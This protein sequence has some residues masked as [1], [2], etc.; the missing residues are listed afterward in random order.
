MTERRLYLD[1]AAGETRGVVT[2]DGRPERLLISRDGDLA[3]QALGARVVARVRAV[4]RANALAFLD[5]G[6]GPDAVLNVTKDQGPLVEGRAL[7]VEIRAEG[8]RDKGAS[9]RLLG[10][11]EG[12]PRLLAAAPTVEEQLLGFAPGAAIRDGTIA[13]SVADGA[14]DEALSTAFPLPGGGSVSVEPTRALIA[15]DV[16]LG[17][18]PGVEAKKATRAANFAALGV[19]A[20]AMRLK[21]LGGLAVIDLVGRGHDAPALLSAARAAFGPDN[22]GVALGAVSRF[23]TLELTVP[24]R[25]RPAV[26]I[27]TDDTGAPSALTRALVLLRALEREAMAD[28]GGRF[29]AV[30][31]AAVARAAASGLAILV[32]RLGARLAVRADP[33]RADS[34]SEVARL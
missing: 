28:G 2:L 12:P 3:V 9:V 13:R 31:S 10:P 32:A 1:V 14:Q 18:R 16:D 15:I 34:Q 21:G 4:D 27:L 5:L 19:A 22:P 8:R 29:E 17:S 33:G 20:R 26:D 6:V 24:R 25:A 23:G 30:A 7:E 11:A